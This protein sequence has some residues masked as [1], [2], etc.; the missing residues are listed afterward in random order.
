MRA[1][2]RD[3][4]EVICDG[5]IRRGPASTPLPLVGRSAADV[6]DEQGTDPPLSIITRHPRHSAIDD[7]PDAIDRHGCFRDIR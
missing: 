6:F 3:R 4:T 7:M 5:G 2:K 1:L